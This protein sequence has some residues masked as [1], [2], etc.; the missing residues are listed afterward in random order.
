LQAFC[1]FNIGCFE[2][3]QEVLKEL[4]TNNIKESKDKELIEG[5]L[6]LKNLLKKNSQMNKM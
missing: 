6:E 1:L 5:Y 2:E 4:E 3:M